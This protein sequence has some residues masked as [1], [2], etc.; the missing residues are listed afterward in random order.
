MLGHEAGY[1][2]TGSYN[3]ALG[4]QAL[5]T[6]A[7]GN[8][9]VAIGQAAGANHASGAL[10]TVT[11][12]IFIGRGTKAKEDDSTNEIVIGHDATGAGNNT[13]TIGSTSV[14]LTKLNGFV[15]IGQDSTPVKMK[16]LTGTTGAA[17][18][19]SALAPHVLT[20]PKIVSATCIV[21]HATNGG[22]FPESADI[23]AAEYQYSLI[24]DSGGENFIVRNSGTNSGSILSKP[25]VITIWYQE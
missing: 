18:G 8:S 17:E 1:G 6:G 22:I 9:N 4:M 3:V 25:F 12:S 16:V 13:V 23:G 19:D 14:T 15:G 2:S 20:G 5:R 10:T 7:Y 24:L 21:R 11:D